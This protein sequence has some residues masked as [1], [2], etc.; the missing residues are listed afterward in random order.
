MV[1][2]VRESERGKFAGPDLGALRE[3][4]TSVL[5]PQYLDRVESLSLLN[6]NWSVEKKSALSLLCVKYGAFSVPS[7][8]VRPLYSFLKLSLEEVPHG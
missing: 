7:P 1:V 4:K 3:R 5:G 2:G 8:T 6:L